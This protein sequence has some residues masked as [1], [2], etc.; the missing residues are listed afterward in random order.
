MPVGA[1]LTGYD[2]IFMVKIHKSKWNILKATFFSI[3]LRRNYR[4]FN[5]WHLII[6][7]ISALAL[8]FYLWTARSNGVP[9]VVDI[10][11]KENFKQ[12]P[13]P[14]LFH[15]GRSMSFNN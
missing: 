10:G 14:A 11:P 12:A 8:A 15:I 2:L 3:I 5:L 7:T 9:L 13:N 4:F 6:I 1:T